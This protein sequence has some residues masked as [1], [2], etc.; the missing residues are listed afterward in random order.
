[1]A[2]MGDHDAIHLDIWVSVE[3]LERDVLLIA[4]DPVRVR[5]DELIPT[6]FHIRVRRTSTS[7]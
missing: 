4:P 6:H 1:M 7:G 3:H 5:E 2:K